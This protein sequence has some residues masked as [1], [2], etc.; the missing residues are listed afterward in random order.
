MREKRTCSHK[1]E[2]MCTCLPIQTADPFVLVIHACENMSG[3]TWTLRYTDLDSR[4]E[5]R[6]CCIGTCRQCGGGLCMCSHE[7]EDLCGDDLL[8]ALY[9]HLYQ[10]THANA[11]GP[12]AAQFRALFLSIFHEEDWPRVQDWLELPENQHVSQMY[13]RN[14]GKD[15]AR[16][17]VYTIVHTSADAE[18]GRYPDADP[19]GSYLSWKRARQELERMVEEEKNEM[20][21]PFDAEL[22]RE[23]CGNDYWEAY[24]EGYAASWFTRFDILTSTLHEIDDDLEGD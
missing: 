8:A 24:Q 15:R 2:C 4:E 7:P 1:P 9:R 6:L 20:D 17:K 12:N 10:T 14:V 13:R 3:E 19:R 23:E 22:Y 16:K 18:K 5:R 21:I 11:P